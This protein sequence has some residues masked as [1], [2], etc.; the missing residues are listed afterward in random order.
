MDV[1]YLKVWCEAL[2]PVSTKPAGTYEEHL[3]HVSARSRAR[4]KV[5]VQFRLRQNLRARL[6]TALKRGLK[7]GSAV[8]DLGCT[9]PE[10]QVHLEAQFQPGMTWE[11]NTLYGWHV[12]HV[13]PLTSF[14]LTDRNQL[15]Q[16][17]H[18]T[19]LQ[20]LW[21][22]DNLSKGAKT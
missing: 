3:A 1:C 10:L 5:D 19:N 15:L 17:C 13:R 8:Q 22:K 21:A 2:R 7:V 20:P 12:D 18:Y 16:A 14:D 11:N 4:R 9:I 6:R